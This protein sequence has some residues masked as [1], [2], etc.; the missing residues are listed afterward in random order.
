V[1]PQ[2]ARS[3]SKRACRARATSSAFAQQA[4]ASAEPFSASAF[5][6]VDL[7]LEKAF[8]ALVN[9]RRCLAQGGEAFIITDAGS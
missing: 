8:V 9:K 7:R 3:S 1:R 6:T 5:E 4:S 2:A